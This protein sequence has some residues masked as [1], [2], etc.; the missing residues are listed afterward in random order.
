MPVKKAKKKVAK[1]ATGGAAGGAASAAVVSDVILMVNGNNEGTI[2]PS[3]TLTV[4]DQAM[5]LARKAGLK[6]YSVRL[7]GVPVNAAEAAAPLAGAR[8]LEVFAKDTRG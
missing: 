5:E 6:S 1:V 4:G 3:A 8:S 7:N 2:K